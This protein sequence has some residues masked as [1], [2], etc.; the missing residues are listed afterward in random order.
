MAFF[1]R[2]LRQTYRPAISKA[3][4]GCSAPRS[5]RSRCTTSSAFDQGATSLSAVHGHPQFVHDGAAS[6]ASLPLT[7]RVCRR[8]EKELILRGV[9]AGAIAGLLAFAFARIFA[10]PAINQA[11]NYESGRDAVIAALDKAAGC[12]PDEGPDIFSGR[13]RQR[14]HRRR[15]IAS[16]GM[17]ALFGWPTHCTWA[18]WAA[19]GRTLAL[20]VAGA[21]S[22]QYLVPF[23]NTRPTALHRPSRD[24]PPAWRALPVHGGPRS[25]CWSWRSGPGSRLK[26]RFGTWNAV[27]IAAAGFAV[28]WRDH[29]APAGTRPAGGEPAPVRQ[30]H[31]PD[32]LPLEERQ[33][34]HRLSRLPADVLF[35]FRCI[36]S[37]RKL[38]LWG[39]IG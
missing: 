34:R 32:A 28:L 38:V 31:P 8:H 18:G 20:L 11:I 14:R 1:H 35:N 30:P 7:G 37:P 19:T 27:L 5:S 10:E 4:S 2:A 33:G 15:M 36:P 16:R 29:G 21:G 22:C 26:T 13:S 39:A 24:H 25:R 3:C 12:P 17:G 6:S 9:L 23:I